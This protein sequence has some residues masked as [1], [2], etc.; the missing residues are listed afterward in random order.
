[1]ENGPTPST[2]NLWGFRLEASSGVICR[3]FR[4]EASSGVISRGFRLEASSGVI[5]GQSTTKNGHFFKTS[6]DP[7]TT[8]CSRWGPHLLHSNPVYYIKMKSE[9]DRVDF[10]NTVD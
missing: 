4:L 6:Q 8:F 2:T 3:G 5:C 9:Y 10:V 7:S 1:M